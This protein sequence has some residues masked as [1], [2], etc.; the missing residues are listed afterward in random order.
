MKQTLFLNRLLIAVLV[1]SL[2]ACNTKKPAPP[3]GTN[4]SWTP[5]TSGDIAA[6]PTPASHGPGNYDLTDIGSTLEG[7]HSYHYTLARHFAGTE[8][9]SAGTWDI[10]YD[11][12]VSSQPPA[13]LLS[14]ADSDHTGWMFG[15]I[16]GVLYTRESEE[17]DC[18]AEITKIS[19]YSSSIDPTLQIPNVLGAAETGQQSAVNGVSARQYTFDASALGVEEPGKASGEIWVAAD[20]GYPVKYILQTEGDEN[21]Y[22]E[23]IQGKMTWDYELTDVNSPDPVLPPQGCPPGR[24][25]VPRMDDAANPVESPGLLSYETSSDAANAAAFYQQQMPAAGYEETST[26]IA[27]GFARLQYMKGSQE[28]TVYVW[29]GSPVEVQVVLGWNLPE[30]A[31]VTP[32]PRPPTS[33]VNLSAAFSDI[34]DTSRTPKLDSYHL[35]VHQVEP[36]WDKTA[37]KMVPTDYTLTADIH[38]RDIHFTT[39][40]LKNGKLDKTFEDYLIGDQEY[41]VVGGALQAPGP[42]IGLEWIS[43]PN[44]MLPI[45]GPASMGTADQGSDAIEGRPVNVLDIDTARA[46]PAAVQ[47]FAN[48]GIFTSIATSAKGTAWEDQDT[49]ALLKLVLDYSM[50]A[51]NLSDKSVLGTGTGRLEI[52]VSQIGKTTV[53]L[54]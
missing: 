1:L 22:G 42:A 43:W 38:G 27:T 28:T 18:Q 34:A 8:D 37:G 54:P 50:K 33:S 47:A 15:E 25:T 23:G 44:H 26:Y 30:P 40:L 14:I 21:F 2:A 12:Q 36:Q 51:I 52:T 13:Y 45:I 16:D 9:G 32:T 17:G 11:L 24:V 29:D 19:K 35:V 48:M 7:L 5:A 53:Q 49:G 3:A 41:K 31:P 6:T 20:G 4:P 39:K 46:D 10:T